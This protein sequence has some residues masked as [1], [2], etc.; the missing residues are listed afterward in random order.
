MK[1]NW[2][3]K[4]VDDM[5]EFEYQNQLYNL[6]INGIYVWGEIRK[7]IF[8]RIINKNTESNLN[9]RSKTQ[10]IISLFTIKNKLSKA[11]QADNIVFLHHK[12]YLIENQLIDPI[13]IDIINEIKNKKETCIVSKK[14]FDDYRDEKIEYSSVERYLFRKKQQFDFNKE[15][16]DLIIDY[17]NKEY[18][19]DL[20]IENLNKII[21][22]MISDVNYYE[23]CFS[24][25]KPKT[26]YTNMFYADTAI[27]VAAKNMGI[28][29][30]DIQYA[31]L[32]KYHIGYYYPRRLVYPYFPDELIL[33]NNT[34]N[35]EYLPNVEKRII[36]KKYNDIDKKEKIVIISQ[37]KLTNEFIE[38][39][40][41]IINDD[42]FSKYELIFKQHP[43]EKDLIG[44]KFKV[45]KATENID[46]EDV[47][48]DSEY[49]IGS[50]SS[51]IYTA[52]ELGAKLLLLDIELTN[53]VIDIDYELIKDKEDIKSIME[54]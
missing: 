49:V 11:K 43:K 32:I 22:D 20:S 50:F 3:A 41:Q 52:F 9:Q 21:S 2:Y 14:T 33:F 24:K 5:V 1:N 29:V 25:I 19:V 10:K 48:N 27:V 37:D 13:T 7:N 18:D 54:R 38:I 40:N 6:E 35:K 31:A 15:Q 42:Y 12:K 36:H 30:I 39:A 44:K 34:W 26:I 51:G 28:K 47:V 46:L 16:S 23:K 8:Y 17:F 53:L 4:M 45:I